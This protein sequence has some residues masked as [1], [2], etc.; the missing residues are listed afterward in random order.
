[1]AYHQ[2][3]LLAAKIYYIG[4]KLREAI[5]VRGMYA[6]VEVGQNW[7][8]EI[9][10]RFRFCSVMLPMRREDIA[11]DTG[12]RLVAVLNYGTTKK[13]SI[14]LSTTRNYETDV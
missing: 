6:H 10:G 9:K 4:K 3:P 1:M 14:F 12:W 7:R 13:G 2:L 8:S 5:T 11:N